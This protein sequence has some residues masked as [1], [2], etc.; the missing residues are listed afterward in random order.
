MI[1]NRILAL[2]LG[3]SSVRA[4]VLEVEDVAMGHTSVMR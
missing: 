3:T 4:L 1:E 2:D